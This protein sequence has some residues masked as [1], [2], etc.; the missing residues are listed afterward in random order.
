MIERCDAL[1]L[2]PHPDDVDLFCGATAS[3][4]ASRGHRV[5]V[6]DLTRGERA[7]N[8]T[9]EGRRRESQAAVRALGLGTERLVVGLPDGG[10]DAR[11]PEQLRGVVNLLRRTHPRVLVAPWH[12]DR[13]PDHRETA[14]LARRAHF[15]CAVH[16]MDTGARPVSRPDVLLYYPCHSDVPIEVGVDVGPRMRQWEEAV[17]CYRSQFERGEGTRPTKLNRPAFLESL[18]ARRRLWGEA[19]GC[20]WAEGFLVE[21]PL[22]A[23]ADLFFPSEEKH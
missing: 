23:S 18:R 10:L 3:L 19:L 4:W 20:D 1:F 6:A 14:E 17:S 13:H 9:V 22:K 7:S 11:D 16:G 12:E 2:S 5:V 15:Y 21:G 8:G